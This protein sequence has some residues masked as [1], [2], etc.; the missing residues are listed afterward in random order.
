MFPNKTAKDLTPIRKIIFIEI[1]KE[2]N[3]SFQSG[4]PEAVTVDFT[5]RWPHQFRSWLEISKLETQ[6][7]EID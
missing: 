3:F 6:T 1:N 2:L 5:K 4:E 7:C